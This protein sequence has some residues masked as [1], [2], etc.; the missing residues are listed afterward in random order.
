M[1]GTGEREGLVTWIS[2]RLTCLV[3]TLI[4]PPLL[5]FTVICDFLRPAAKLQQRR[6]REKKTDGARLFDVAFFS[7]NL[8]S[9]I[10]FSAFSLD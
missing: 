2:W 4:W 8:S 3:H 10:F 7:S 1:Y 9:I 5:F 6:K